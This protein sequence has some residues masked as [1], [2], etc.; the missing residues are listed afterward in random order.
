MCWFLAPTSKN[1]MKTSEDFLRGS[2]KLAWPSKNKRDFSKNQIIFLEHVITL[3]RL[4]PD[5]WKTNAVKNYPSPTSMTELQQFLGMVNQLS[6]LIPNPASINDLL[7]YPLKWDRQWIWTQEQEKVEEII[8]ST[9]VLAHYEVHKKCIIAADA[10]N[11]GLGVVLMQEDNMGNRK[12]ISF[13]S[14]SLADHETWYTIVEKEA[15]AAT[16][17]CMKFMDYVLGKQFLLEAD[18]RPLVPLLSST[19]LTKLPPRIVRFHLCMMW[20][21]P[22]V[23]HVQ[24][25][26][27]VIADS[28]SWAP[29]EEPSDAELEEVESFCNQSMSHTSKWPHNT[30]T[31]GCPAGIPSV[32]SSDGLLPT[33]M[34]SHNA[35]SASSGTLFESQK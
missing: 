30:R 27:Q 1:M 11:S 28:V 31:S 21:A 18:H 19:N 32:R 5:P 14:R 13:M 25:N 26:K 2:R 9:E 6:H 8:M 7:R 10:S 3:Q 29:P 34:A 15:L 24:G 17:A 35:S 16:W 12:P 23:T 4:Q 33:G 20:Y 22:E